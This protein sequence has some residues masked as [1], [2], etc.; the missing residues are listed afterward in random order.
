MENNN[1]TPE[2]TPGSDIEYTRRFLSEMEATASHPEAIA[3][4]TSRVIKGYQDTV[5]QFV[6]RFAE[7]VKAVSKAMIAEDGRVM[8]LDPVTNKP[9]LLN[10]TLLNLA[11]AMPE[12]LTS[13][14]TTGGAVILWFDDQRPKQHEYRQ[15]IEENFVKMSQS[16]ARNLMGDFATAHTILA[17]KPRHNLWPHPTLLIIMCEP[18]DRKKLHDEIF[19]AL[20]AVLAEQSQNKGRGGRGT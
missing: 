13:K 7:N 3:A 16:L 1:K 4:E 11:D 14:L 15:N 10:A 6:P 20:E 12:K 9:E 17:R 2:E 18:R 19:P 5:R 8:Q